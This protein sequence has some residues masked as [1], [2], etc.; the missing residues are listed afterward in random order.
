MAMFGKRNRIRI[1]SGAYK[2]RFVGMRFGGGLVTNPEVQKNPPVNVEGYGLWAQEN[3][4]T[5]FFEGNT[6]KVVAELKAQGIEAELV[7]VK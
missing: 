2:D 5:E 4:A 6:D 7:E 3:A 1:T